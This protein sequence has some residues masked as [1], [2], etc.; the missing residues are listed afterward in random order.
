MEFHIQIPDWM[1]TS[2]EKKRALVVVCKCRTSHQL[3]RVQ[4]G[5]QWVIFRA[6][7]W[8]NPSHPPRSLQHI[9]DVRI[10]IHIEQN[11]RPYLPQKMPKYLKSLKWICKCLLQKF[12]RNIELSL[13]SLGNS[14]FGSEFWPTFDILKCFKECWSNVKTISFS[15]MKERRL[16]WPKDSYAKVW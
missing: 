11:L 8:C 14:W 5:Y 16:T 4:K 15:G 6:W 13:K 9:N 2:L 7:T 10:H 12:W 3:T 1:G